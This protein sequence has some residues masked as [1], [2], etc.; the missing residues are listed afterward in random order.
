MPHHGVSGEKAV[1]WK[2]KVKV[3]GYPVRIVERLQINSITA[4]CFKFEVCCLR[5]ADSE[6]E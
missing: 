6:I 4:I 3:V 1:A 5:L 2:A